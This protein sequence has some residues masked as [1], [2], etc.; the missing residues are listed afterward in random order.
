VQHFDFFESFLEGRDLWLWLPVKSCEVVLVSHRA[1]SSHVALSLRCPLRWRYPRSFL[2]K[3]IEVFSVEVVLEVGLEG[4]SGVGNPVP[5]EV[6]EEGVKFDLGDGE[7]ML[8]GTQ[9]A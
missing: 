5:V 6:G 1:A 8:F 7:P 9:H 4:S 2:F 3:S